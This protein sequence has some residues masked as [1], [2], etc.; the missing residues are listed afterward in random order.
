MEAVKLIEPHKI[1]VLKPCQV[2]IIYLKVFTFL[3]CRI[4]V[5]LSVLSDSFPITFL[6]MEQLLLFLNSQVN[7][8]LLKLTKIQFSEVSVAI[9][10]IFHRNM[11]LS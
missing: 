9:L 3:Q 1:Q 4:L 5:Y 10:D 2:Y 6:K 8:T 11:K 7:S